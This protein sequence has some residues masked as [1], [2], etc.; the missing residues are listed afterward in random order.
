[1]L[2]PK[3]SVS[4]LLFLTML[5]GCARM[6]FYTDPDVKGQETG[7]KF[8]TAKP[9]LLVARTGA[10]DK[11]VEISLLYIPDLAKP[12][13]AKPESGFGSANLT[14]ALSNGMLTS[15]GQQTDTKVPDLLTAFGALSKDLATA[16]KTAKEASLLDQAAID[17][18]QVSR[19]LATIAS[20][21][22]KYLQQAAKIQALTSI[23]LQAG[24]GIVGT[25]RLV[26]KLLADPNKAE[27]R[28]VEAM[29]HLKNALSTWEKQIGKPSSATSGPSLELR[30]N[31]D[32]L[33]VQVQAQLAKI[34]PKEPVQPTFTLY[35][36]DNSSGTTVVREVKF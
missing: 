31:I 27:S 22:E 29:I 35:E 20:D 4:A 32:A 8:F 13:Y 11:P 16:R 2:W 5:G 10:K 36:I 23:E 7:I 33:Q 24:A 1:M 18:T 28:V 25:L 15:F 17:Y 34:S 21:L 14:L 19:D 9:Y 26:S 6:A 12:V 30:R 3:S